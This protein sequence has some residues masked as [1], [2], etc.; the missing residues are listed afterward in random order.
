[1]AY[2]AFIRG[3]TIDLCVPSKLAIEDGWADWFN[4]A[5]VTELMG[6]GI[7]PNL[8]ENQE[9]FFQEIVDRRRLVFL[10]CDKGGLLKGTISLSSLDFMGGSCQISLVFGVKQNP[11]R[12]SQLESMALVTEHAFEKMRM[13]RVWAGQAYPA[14]RK[15]NHLLESI[16]Y[17][18]EG[19][20]RDGFIKGL[21]NS[22]TVQISC[23]QKD[24]LRIK[25]NRGSLWG[26]N[27]YMLEIMRNRPSKSI[28]ERILPILTSYQ[29]EQFLEWERIENDV[30]MRI[31]NNADAE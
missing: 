3:E 1:M 9:A 5:N 8:K 21:S 7:F 31:G 14:L 23:T 19:I 15:W 10:I 25:S 6:H 28:A 30:K 20:F 2:T 11:K 29:E 26:G 18:T 16:G 13:Q 4:D 12:L 27:E 22:D 17:R 24:Y